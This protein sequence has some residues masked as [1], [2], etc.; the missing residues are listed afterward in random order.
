M[1]QL[2]N[3]KQL[4]TLPSP[5]PCVKF[6]FSTIPSTLFPSQITTTYRRLNATTD[7]PSEKWHICFAYTREWYFKKA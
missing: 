1:S 2:V 3:T 5:R 4:S 7:P 6:P